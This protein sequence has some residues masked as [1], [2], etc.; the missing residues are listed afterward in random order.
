M[1]RSNIFYK[2]LQEFY[3]FLIYLLISINDFVY[4][5]SGPVFNTFKNLTYIQTN[6][7]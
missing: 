7:S 3:W 4:D 1:I 6:H 2:N 5:I